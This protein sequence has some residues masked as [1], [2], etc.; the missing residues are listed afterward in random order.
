MKPV[1]ITT[2]TTGQQ[3]Y[4]MNGTRRAD[5]PRFAWLLL[6]LSWLAVPH[7]P[8]RAQEIGC[9]PTVEEDCAVDFGWIRGPSGPMLSAF[10]R[11]GDG[12]VLEGDILVE[13]LEFADLVTQNNDV[14]ALGAIRPTRLWSQGVV[15]YV[16]DPAPPNP[17]RVI[18]A[19]AHFDA[20]TA[21]EFV[22]PTSQPNFVVFMPGN[23][24]SSFVGMKGGVQYVPLA[25]GCDT[26]VTIHEI[27][28]PIGLWHEQ[29]A[30]TAISSSSSATRASSPAWRSTSTPTRT[31]LHSSGSGG[32]D[33]PAMRT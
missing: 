7:G 21:L 26:G 18:N 25:T 6:T 2:T 29:C 23:G 10:E 15:L 33:E 19:I 14:G 4:A 5:L 27:G 31:E 1:V 3:R 28:R 11:G 20:Y 8:A 16:V 22:P 24:R 12:A 30:T 32:S 9:V 17:A 13:E